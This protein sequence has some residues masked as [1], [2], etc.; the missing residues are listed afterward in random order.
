M[1]EHSSPPDQFNNRAALY[2]IVTTALTTLSQF[3]GLS[4]VKGIAVNAAA[5]LIYVSDSGNGRVLLWN[6]SSSSVTTVAQ[7]G[8]SNPSGLALGAFPLF[9]R[10]CSLTHRTVPSAAARGRSG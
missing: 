9:D 1:L 6:A 4:A 10:R 5:S 2:N 7:A 3:T 8:L